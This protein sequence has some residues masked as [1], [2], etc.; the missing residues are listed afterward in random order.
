MVSDG[1]HSVLIISLY[2]GCCC[3]LASVVTEQGSDQGSRE[4]LHS[5]CNEPTVVT[6]IDPG[7]T[8]QPT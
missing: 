2:I 6:V 4:N 7:M 8:D 3:H 1:F 5:P